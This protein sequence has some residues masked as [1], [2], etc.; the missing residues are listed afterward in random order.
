MN[1]IPVVIVEEILRR[2]SLPR[3]G[4]VAVS[5]HAVFRLWMFK[6][7]VRVSGFVPRKLSKI[8]TVLLK[9]MKAGENLLIEMAQWRRR[10]SLTNV[11]R[12]KVEAFTS[13]VSWVWF[14]P[15]GFSLGIP[16]SLFSQN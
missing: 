11:I 16:V 13:Y 10:S 12:A 2:M 9:N 14:V 8:R 1:K 6:T 5:I 3:V 4:A 7:T 15:R